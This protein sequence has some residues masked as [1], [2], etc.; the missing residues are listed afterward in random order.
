MDYT[1][2][3][4]M[5]VDAAETAKVYGAGYD[6]AKAE[7]EEMARKSRNLSYV[8]LGASAVGVIVGIMYAKNHGKS[9]LGY[10]LLGW[11]IAGTATVLIGSLVIAKRSIK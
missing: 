1:N 3:A 11:L 6:A 2:L 9:K 4:L 10:G 7:Q 8:S 5:S